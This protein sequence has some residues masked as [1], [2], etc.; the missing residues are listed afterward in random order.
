[1]LRAHTSNSALVD[2]CSGCSM[3]V[4]LCCRMMEHCLSMYKSITL[5]TCR[6]CDKVLI[7]PLLYQLYVNMAM[8]FLFISFSLTLSLIVYVCM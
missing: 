7:T 3:S 5:S 8:T 4:N 1:M 6:F 2:V